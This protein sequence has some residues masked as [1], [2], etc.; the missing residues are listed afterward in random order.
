M[1]HDDA[2]SN[3]ISGLPSQA[4][5]STAIEPVTDIDLVIERSKSPL[6]T[7]AATQDYQ[8][9][10][11]SVEEAQLLASP[12]ADNFLPSPNRLLV[13]GSLGLV[14]ALGM[15]ALAS[16]LITYNT[17]VKAQAVVE[18]V[19]DVQLIESGMGGVVDTIFVKEYDSLKP[20][21]VIASFENIPLRTKVTQIEAQ[22]AGFEGRITQV[23]GQLAALDRRRLAE[24]TWLQQLTPGGVKA[25]VL[26]QFEYSKQLLLEH[27]SSLYT[28]LKQER[29][30]LEQTQQ[31]IDNLIIHSPK[32]GTVYDLELKRLGQAISADEAIAKIMPNEAGLEIKALLPDIDIKN[33]EVGY[34][35]KLNLAECASFSFGSLPG[36]ISS[37]QPAQSE[38]AAN[39]SKSDNI[40]DNSHIVTVEAKARALQSGARTCELL[41]GMEGELT[42]IAKQEKLLNFFLR[43]LRLKTNI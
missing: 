32:A 37:I 3:S 13:F 21:Q 40:P 34:P 16:T 39:L 15:G 41:P 11:S 18:P 2:F 42:I 35:A 33:V 17:T 26:P 22:I 25:E 24:A 30:Q 31:Q 6:G 19:G 23:E 5:K 8:S 14:G 1:K 4:K 12:V 29:R 10:Q 43:K 7:L 38:L 9:R 27:R 20:G 36:Q 28:Q